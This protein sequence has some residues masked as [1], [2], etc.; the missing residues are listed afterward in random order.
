MVVV[1]FGEKYAARRGFFPFYQYKDLR[2]PGFWWGRGSEYFTH[3][4]SSD[5]EE[6]KALVGVGIPKYGKVVKT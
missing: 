2:A 5:I 6:V 3:C 4:L 1:K